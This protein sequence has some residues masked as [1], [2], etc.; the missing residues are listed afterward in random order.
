M[1]VMAMGL[2]AAFINGDNI[3]V[4]IRQSTLTIKSQACA[5]VVYGC[6]DF[7]GYPG[8]QCK[9]QLDLPA[10]TH[11]A[12]VGLDVAWNVWPMNAIELRIVMILSQ[13]V[14]HKWHMMDMAS[15]KIQ[16]SLNSRVDECKGALFVAASL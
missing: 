7:S 8:L 15:T 10:L 9:L 14:D 4:G 5:H 13:F 2:N 11:L 3:G 12:M 1:V 6:R 16:T